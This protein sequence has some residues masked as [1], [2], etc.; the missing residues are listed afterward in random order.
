[1]FLQIFVVYL[2]AIFFLQFK[3][4]TIMKTEIIPFDFS[5]RNEEHVSLLQKNLEV[6]GYKIGSA[7]ELNNKKFGAATKKAL[8]AF[9]GDFFCP[10][11]SL[12]LD[13]DTINTLKGQLEKLHQL[14]GFVT[15][16]NNM[17]IEGV[18]V[19]AYK[20]SYANKDQNG[21]PVNEE[22]IGSTVS[23]SD[24]S[25]CMYLNIPTGYIGKDGLLNSN[26]CVKIICLQNQQ[27]VPSTELIIQDIG[28]AINISSDAFIY[29]G[30]SVYQSVVTML[31][32]NG[33]QAEDLLLK[34]PF[35]IADISSF[36]GIDKEVIMRLMFSKILYENQDPE[37]IFGYLYQN[38]PTNVPLQLFDE[39]VQ[40]WTQYKENIVQQIKIG[41]LLMSE[42]LLDEVLDTA[43]KQCI[44]GDHD[45]GW[46]GSVVNFLEGQKVELA[47]EKIL[48]GDKSVF[49]IIDGADPNMGN[50]QK[51][52]I[53]NLFIANLYDFSAFIT[54]LKQNRS[55]YET[56][57][58]DVDL[59]LLYFQISR[60][61]RN[62]LDLV[63]TIM[64]KWHEIVDSNH[65]EDN[66]ISIDYND[67]RYIATISINEW[68]E[69]YIGDQPIPGDFATP[70]DYA[71]FIYQN[72]QEL[73]PDIAALS[74]ID[75][76]NLTEF[77]KA[78]E[79]KTFLFEYPSFDILK[80]RIED[81]YEIENTE[82]PE[83]QEFIEQFKTIQ[84]VYRISP[85]P[86]AAA[87]LLNNN[88]RNSG[89][90]YFLGK[91]QLKKRFKDQLPKE[92]IDAV[93]DIA[94]ASF[95]NSLAA[96]ANISSK[97]N[98]VSVATI[99]GNSGLEDILKLDDNVLEQKYPDIEE[100]IQE[101]KTQFPNIKD[102][103]G[104]TDYCECPHDSS[105]YSSAAYLADLL[106]FL[107][108]REAE[109]KSVRE[110][111]NEKRSDISQIYLNKHNT[112]TMMPYID[113][114]CEVLEEEVLKTNYPNYN[115]NEAECQST[116]SSKELCAAPEHVLVYKDKFAK[117]DFTAYDI[118]KEKD[119]PM[120]APLNLYQTEIRAYLEK[121][122]IKRYELMQTFTRAAT[123]TIYSQTPQNASI[124][125]EYFG[126]TSLEQDIV[127]AIKHY[128]KLLHKNM[129]VSKFMEWTGFSPTEVIDLI[130]TSWTGISCNEL[131]TTQCTFQDKN[132]EGDDKK[133]DEVHKFRRLWA[134]SGWKIWELDLLL[135]NV[136]LNS[137]GNL[138][139]DTLYNLML[140]KQQQE[141]LGLACENLLAFYDNIN[142]QEV[143]ENGEIK[144]SL[145]DKLFLNK[146]INAKDD[147][148][149]SDKSLVMACLSISEADYDLLYGKKYSGI[150][151]LALLS[152]LYRSSVLAKKLKISIQ[153]LYILFKLVFN[154]GGVKFVNSY[155]LEDVNEIITICKAIKESKITISEYEYLVEYGYDDENAIAL[156]E[157]QLEDYYDALKATI[158]VKP[159]DT[160]IEQNDLSFTATPEY[161]NKFTAHLSEIELYSKPEYMEEIIRVIECR[162]DKDDGEIDTWGDLFF[163]EIK[164]SLYQIELE[165]AAALIERYEIV[166]QYFNKT[167][168]VNA[169]KNHVA[170]FFDLASGVVDAYLEYPITQISLLDRIFEYLPSEANIDKVNI[171]K[172]LILI[173]KAAL[174]IKKNDINESDFRLLLNIQA[175]IKFD[176]FGFK[177]SVGSGVGLQNLLKL[178]AME[179]LQKLYGTK[180]DKTL[181]DI[182]KNS[183]E[184]TFYKDLC[185]L[186]KWD[187]TTFSEIINVDC[188]NL[189]DIRDFFKPETYT[190]IDNC[191]AMLIATGVSVETITGWRERDDDESKSVEVKNAAKAHYSIDAWLDELPALQKPIREAKSNALASYLIAND[192]RW[193]DKTDLYNYFLLDTEM[194]SCMKTSRIVQATLS[195]QLFVQRC[196]LNLENGIRINEKDDDNWKQWDW[197]KKYR[198][199][200][201]NRKIFLYPENWIE[202]EL[203]DDKTPF[204]KE[205]EDEINQSDITQEHAETVFENYLQKLHTVSN[206][207]VCGIYHELVKSED[208]KRTLES[209]LH[210]IARTKSAPFEYYYR[211]YNVLDAVW[212]HWEKVELDIK[213]DVVIPM[214]Y[215]RKLHLFWLSTMEQAQDSNNTSTY[216]KPPHKYT[217]IQL[218]WSIL[219]N[220]K[221]TGS[222]YSHKKIIVDKHVSTINYSLVANYLKSNEIELGVWVFSEGNNNTSAALS[223]CFYFDGHV[224]K[225]VSSEFTNFNKFVDEMPD[226]V[227]PTQVTTSTSCGMSAETKLLASRLYSKMNNGKADIYLYQMEHQTPTQA[228]TK[229]Q[230]IGLQKVGM[231]DNNVVPIYSMSNNQDCLIIYNKGGKTGNTYGGQTGN[232][233]ETSNSGNPVVPSYGLLPFKL[234]STDNQDP[235]IVQALHTN[236]D[237]KLA[238]AQSHLDN[239]FFY[240]DSKRSFFI[241]PN[242]K[243]PNNYISYPFYHAYTNLFIN[244][245]NRYGIDGLLNRNIQIAP[246][247]YKPENE[248]N[249]NE[250][251]EPTNNIVQM[252][253][254]YKDVIGDVLDFNLSGAY[255]VYN[256][257]L[258]FHTP[259][260]IACKLS[261]NQKYEEAMKW[262]HYIFDPTDKSSEE[263][264]K[265]FWI[266]KPF[267]EMSTL[268]NR[269]QQIKNILENISDHVAVVNSWLGNPYK[270]HLV[271][272]HRPVAYQR[273]VVMKYIDNLI[274]WADQLFCQDS[275][276][277]NNEATLLY[278]LVYEILGRRPIMLP[279]NNLKSPLKVNYNK[280]KTDGWF[281]YLE[282]YYNSFVLDY[283]NNESIRNVANSAFT[284]PS[285]YMQL[286]NYTGWGTARDERAI[287]PEQY[288]ILR[289]LKA[290]RRAFDA[291]KIGDSDPEP[292]P[293][294]DADNF[295]IPYNENLLSYWDLVEDRL[296]KLR[297]CMNIDGIVRELPLFEPPIDPAMLVKAAA[298][299]L[300]IADALNDITAPQPYYRFRVILQKAIEFTGE[301]KQLGDKLLSALEKKDAETLNILRSY[302]EI[303]LQQA[304]KQLRRLQIEEAKENVNSILES[305]KITERKKEYYASREYMNSLEKASFS[306][307]SSATAITTGVAIGKMVAS[308]LSYIPKISA[309]LAGLGP[310]LDLETIDGAKIAKAADYI[311]E[312]LSIRA[313]LL[314]RMSSLLSTQ[315]GYQRRMEDW[316]FQ[317]KMA[318]MELTQLSKQ[319]TAA[320]IRLMMAEKELENLEMQIE[321]SQAI[322][323]YYQ[324]KYTNEALYNW[325]ITQI[326]TIYFQAYKLAYDMAKKA[327]KCY[328]HE[329]GIYN[330]ATNIINFNNWDSL[331]RGLLSGDMLIH[332]LHCLDAA[333]IDK[334]KRTLELTKHISLAQMFPANLIEL[335]TSETKSTEL[336]LP[337][338]LFD[339]D[340]PGHYMRRIKSVSVTIPNVAGPYTTVSCMLNLQSAKVRKNALLKNGKYEEDIANDDTGRFNYQIGGSINQSI[341]TSS[342]QNDS[343][344]FEFNFG[345]ERYLPFENAGVISNWQMS[346]PAGVNQFD[347][348]SISDVILHINYTA[349]YDGVLAD[350]AK[351]ALDTKLPKA[352]TI[353]FSPKQDF[354]DEWNK[355]EGNNPNMNFNLKTEHL[356]FFLRENPEQV[357]VSNTNLVLISKE[358]NLVNKTLTLTQKNPLQEEEVVSLIRFTLKGQSEQNNVPILCGDMYIYNA[359]GSINPPE[360]NAALV[361][362]MAKK[363]WK[364]DFGNN[365][366]IAKVEDII[367][368]FSLDA[369]E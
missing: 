14:H 216:D 11:G 129:S 141:E 282:D 337:E 297:N 84:H 351:E 49:D 367:I 281:S 210:V 64:E 279:E 169:I 178:S 5:E 251:Y 353:L 188:L 273:T 360:E 344:M 61:V 309:G 77:S 45:E 57:Q 73:Y 39:N 142:T 221:W 304:M 235:N 177:E 69:E 10:Q 270:P 33:L 70:N 347:L 135:R 66:E 85:S 354:P 260:Y 161:I 182:I 171:Y 144:V 52:E 164:E 28:N 197:M 162:S 222:Q 15:N 227:K 60:V 3:K 71:K 63:A 234:I 271:A 21:E 364:I 307:S 112:N 237:F 104:D 131:I 74:K 299:G 253:E 276:E 195:V 53:A 341:C 324:Y 98:G 155:T 92:E 343:G 256:W 187:Y 110:Y 159:T 322:K 201:A 113:L 42:Y 36:T 224:Y 160:D 340:Y 369:E 288:G 241:T 211:T 245:L 266:P 223:G 138:D 100:L 215:N 80:D 368:G 274:A 186:T 75:E 137:N 335:I 32:N 358:S 189:D 192:Q 117:K 346:L 332:D 345:D 132:I 229:V 238:L 146:S 95:S 207:M 231:A 22:M 54:E 183:D 272:R 67:I 289:K 268:E 217:E 330:P 25:F 334:N 12:D 284:E 140:F 365:I 165:N 258:F 248:F 128:N 366:D 194:S 27:V 1:M 286:S 96:F 361:T 329:L 233:G 156:T 269:V 102:L 226:D 283:S 76:L 180:N 87:V 136:I 191:M 303:N 133:F 230:G 244:E 325:M 277:S 170:N 20:I 267:F 148:D 65:E 163:P 18:T 123:K 13:L 263:S 174:T 342:A 157:Q 93:F 328:L 240:Q 2:T 48:E 316:Q 134:K 82:D 118:I 145:Y 261:Q 86:E 40:D 107:D 90:V 285:F 336:E 127:V 265:K 257:E 103:F 355:M 116:L 97:L 200:E 114:V 47:G 294:I 111:L 23:L 203:R 139:G 319:L 125:A 213:G 300:S 225:T 91:Q 51:E 35:D 327:E 173:H 202:P 205:L 323:E 193:N 56:L 81:I 181:F 176:W 72:A 305:I 101:L 306:S 44:I 359:I 184:N 228:V 350:K 214:V 349:L 130:Q 29:T 252:A 236:P 185:D 259:L 250:V 58:I 218:G 31:D 150:K 26:L 37:A 9:K 168:K 120:Y 352:G 17:P 356:P 41:L 99:L 115:R 291:P 126:L 196:F 239:P 152:Y 46:I 88:I 246:Q 298:A 166:V 232:Q 362:P 30:K 310:F 290:Q 208:E 122:G 83:E 151:N 190:R 154:D 363:D 315:A 59:L 312:G 121:M 106:C 105:V 320:E 338:W 308:G 124:A 78:G 243:S 68:E 6:L 254:Q 147:I 255:S 38:Y 19:T 206:L 34:E 321:Q 62:N 292:L 296:F 318:N 311:M 275:M 108:E 4:I 209:I 89:Q 167:Y 247:E 264:P 339:M 16:T 175:K 333:Y 24:G 109:N 326:S 262:F 8:L 220:K 179:K 242:E 94:S 301:V 43:C 172:I 143:Y 357:E 331:K 204:F 79:I 293:R 7:D 295:C 278:I 119:Y 314:E 302:Q 149:A 249:F 199:W 313:Q 198:L 55:E 348:S 219:K 158:L 212:S 280:I 153:E 287:K 317:A 50:E